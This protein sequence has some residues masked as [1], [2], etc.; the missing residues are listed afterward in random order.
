MNNQTPEALLNQIWETIY[1][2]GAGKYRG[3]VSK[4]QR[5]TAFKNIDAIKALA[6]LQA[7]HEKELKEAVL[8]EREACAKVC[9]E[10]LPS[11][12]YLIQRKIDRLNDINEAVASIRARSQS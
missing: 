4:Q 9:E 1:D 12:G 6:S 2:H 8:A 5:E 7:K 3:E 10:L 11:G